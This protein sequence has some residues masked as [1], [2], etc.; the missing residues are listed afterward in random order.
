MQSCFCNCTVTVGKISPT[1][2][3][4]SLDPVV[5]II[6]HYVHVCLCLCVC[7]WVFKQGLHC[8][9]FLEN[10]HIESHFGALRKW[11]TDAEVNDFLPD[12]IKFFEGVVEVF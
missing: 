6:F 2:S 8:C 11:D 1:T 7:M 12:V 3:H 10:E 9:R 5:L 4:E